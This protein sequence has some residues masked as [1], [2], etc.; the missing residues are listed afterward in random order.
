VSTDFDVVCDKHAQYRHLGQRM[1]TTYS[2]GYGRNDVETQGVI[3]E[4]IIDHLGCGLRIVNSDVDLPGHY[5]DA[6]H[7]KPWEA[8]PDGH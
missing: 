1:G 7:P 4:W 6:E 8:L 3:A 2:F 5:V